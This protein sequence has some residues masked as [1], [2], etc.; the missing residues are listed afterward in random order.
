MFLSHPLTSFTCPVFLF[1]AKR[2][3]ILRDIVWHFLI[4]LYILY[5]LNCYWFK[6]IL[7]VYGSFFG[8]Y[9]V[10]CN[11]TTGLTSNMT[12]HF[13]NRKMPMGLQRQYSIFHLHKTWS[14][15]KARVSNRWSTITEQCFHESLAKWCVS[16]QIAFWWNEE[17]TR[18]WSRF[19]T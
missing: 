6:S 3:C 8:H 4:Y 2:F 19:D 7:W 15:S 16:S 14:F 11:K 9:F 17:K 10:I 12:K 18:W 13:P 5:F 1:C